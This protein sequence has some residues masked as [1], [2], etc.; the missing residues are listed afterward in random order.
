MMYWSA[1]L[2]LTVCRFVVLVLLIKS[3]T[4]NGTT[5]SLPAVLIIVEHVE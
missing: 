4:L 5:E 1:G 2:R 3:E